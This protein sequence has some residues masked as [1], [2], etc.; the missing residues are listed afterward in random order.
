M[1]KSVEVEQPRDARDWVQV[2]AK[3]REPSTF[4]SI[5]ELVATL[6]PFVALWAL[7]WVSLSVSYWLAFAIAVL[8]GGFLVRIFVIQHDCG[9]SSATTRKRPRR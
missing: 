3:Y 2:L 5:W 7:A 6:V 9:H 8:N 1:Q 4:R